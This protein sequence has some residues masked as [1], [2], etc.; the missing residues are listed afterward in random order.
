VVL[1]EWIWM[2]LLGWDGN[3]S[4]TRSIVMVRITLKSFV[5]LLPAGLL[6]F[7]VG[8]PLAYGQSSS[9]ALGQSQ[10]EFLEYRLR[11]GEALGDVAQ[12]FRIPVAEL[13][14]LNGISDPARLQVGQALK[15]PN[16]FARQVTELQGERNRLLAEKA[17][18]AQQVSEEQ[19]I[20]AMK[21]HVLRRM[22]A[23]HD[24]LAQELAAVGRWR[25]SAQVLSIMLF[26][27]FAWGLLI[28]KDRA[29]R[30]RQIATLMQE[31]T[32]LEVAKE[33]Y[34]LA[35]AQL[36]FRY[37]KLYSGRSEKPSQLATEGATF[38]TRT[39]ETGCAQLEQYLSAIKTEREKEEQ[40]LRS[41]QR[42]FDLLRHPFRELH[43]RYRLRY[44][45]A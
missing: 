31:N 19:H 13:A 3:F 16:I 15:I 26:G 12:L 14:Q 1:K 18:V 43:Q 5:A 27:V 41:E 34:R 42:I 44:H 28:N 11:Q 2:R 37:Q 8:F 25:L 38:L 7:L 20:L 21:E 22:E 17:Q 36:E 30:G 45:S 24:V 10:A 32:A 4:Q 9:P 33:K 23:S 35:A 40:L 39:F 6:F 29:G